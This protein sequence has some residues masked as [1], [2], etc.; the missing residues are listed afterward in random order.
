LNFN[1]DKGSH[2]GR[3]SASNRHYYNSSESHRDRHGDIGTRFRDKCTSRPSI[4]SNPPDG[5]HG[6]A[7]RNVETS[8]KCG[9][10]ASTS[11]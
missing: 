9:V 1:L 2:V 4:L 10:R 7:R 6:S 11:E 8:R 5:P 3:V